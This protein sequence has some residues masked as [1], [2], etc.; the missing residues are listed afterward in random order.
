MMSLNILLKIFFGQ[1]VLDQTYENNYTGRGICFLTSLI[2]ENET[3][4]KIKPLSNSFK[5]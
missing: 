4:N 1:I 3:F 2:N 5:Y